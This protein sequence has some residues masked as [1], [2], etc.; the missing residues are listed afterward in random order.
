ML[1]LVLVRI[2]NMIYF[3]LNLNGSAKILKVSFSTY[4]SCPLQTQVR[5]ASLAIIVG[6]NK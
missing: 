1:I 2:P 3:C 4:K 6:V 5:F